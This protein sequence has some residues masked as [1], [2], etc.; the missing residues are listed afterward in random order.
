MKDGHKRIL[1]H[2][3]FHSIKAGLQEYRMASFIRTLE[4]KQL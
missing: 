3:K 2:Q 4:Q 1:L